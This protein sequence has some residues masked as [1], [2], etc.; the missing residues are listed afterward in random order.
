MKTTRG[1]TLMSLLIAVALAGLAVW[2]CGGQQATQEEAGTEATSGAEDA[3]GEQPAT[4][5]TEVS[6]ARGNEIYQ[7]RC[8]MCHGEGGKGDGPAGAALEPKPRDHTNAAYMG[9]LSDEE[10]TNVI[11]NGK[12]TGMPAHKGMLTD[13]EVQSLI[14]KVRSLSQQ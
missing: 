12:G 13:A 9:T 1:L 2:G 6:L 4:A 3:G 7:Q 5:D 8:A 14:L 11:L 10:I